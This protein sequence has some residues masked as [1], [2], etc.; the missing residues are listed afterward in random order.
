MHT[1]CVSQK[2]TS[3]IIS[4][5][6]AMS[7]RSSNRKPPPRKRRLPALLRSSPAESDSEPEEHDAF[8]P[9]QDS[10]NNT[11][12]LLAQTQQAMAET[13]A[14]SQENTDRQIKALNDSLQALIK[15]SNVTTAQ[16][17]PSPPNPF[18]AVGAG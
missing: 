1:Y 11:L 17:L 5:L 12:A 4:D 7:K 13:M 16:D 14:K 10:I 2:K 3:R 6:L 8:Q 9:P 18:P 15:Q